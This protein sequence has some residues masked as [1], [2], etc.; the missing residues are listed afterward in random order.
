MESMESGGDALV[1]VG[2]FPKM[3][4]SPSL[5]GIFMESGFQVVL[6]QPEQTVNRDRGTYE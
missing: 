6:N 1:S 2:H 5:L 4:V 3:G